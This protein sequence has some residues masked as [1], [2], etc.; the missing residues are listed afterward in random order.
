TAVQSL[1]VNANLNNVP[2][3]IANSFVPGLAAEGTISG[4]AK[5][6]GTLAAPAVDFD[7]DWKDAATSQT[8]GAGLKALGLSTTGKFADNR[9]DFDANLSG[10]AETGL[11]ANGNVVIAGTA[12][13]NLD[14][15]ANLNN[16]PASIANSF[17]PGLA[18]EGTISGTAKASGTPTAP[19]V[20]FDL[21]WKDAAT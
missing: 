13:Q 1:D 21:D 15:N 20:D 10:P 6:S 17:V 2:A 19:A 7:L 4:T 14:V 8:K 12:V 5:A 9:L 16:V 11:K 18:A 3:S